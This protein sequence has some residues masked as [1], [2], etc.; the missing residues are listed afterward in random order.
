M[1]LEYKMAT[2]KLKLKS[3]PLGMEVEKSESKLKLGRRKLV[4]G[5]KKEKTV[6]PTTKKVKDQPKAKP[7]K[8]PV[9]KKKIEEEPILES[10][11]SK[12]NR[13]KKELDEFEVWSNKQPLQVG[14]LEDFL[15]RFHPAFSKKIIRLVMR[16]QTISVKYLKNVAI[17]GNRFN[18]NGEITSEI[19]KKERDYSHK[20]LKTAITKPLPQPDVKEDASTTPE[21]KTQGLES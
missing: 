7:K 6:V 15:R 19:Q 16:D 10:K 21:L 11:T 2:L 12:C 17:G 20:K 13:L 1:I 5:N 8:E 18:L 4:L 3:K 14:I 9:V